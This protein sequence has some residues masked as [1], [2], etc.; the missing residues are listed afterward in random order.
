MVAIFF[1]FKMVAICQNVAIS[2][3]NDGHFSKYGHFVQNGDHLTPFV[4][5][6]AILQN[7]GHLLNEEYSTIYLAQPNNYFSSPS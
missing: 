5:M 4:K 3:Q 2:F 1:P 7:G 6:V